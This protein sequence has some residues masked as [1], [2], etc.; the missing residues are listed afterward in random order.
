MVSWAA[1]FNGEAAVIHNC[2]GVTRAIEHVGSTALGI[3]SKDVVDVLVGVSPAAHEAAVADLSRGGFALERTR[4]TAE[5]ERH[6]WLSRLV[7]AQRV[8]VVDL[9]E[10]EGRNG[11][12]GRRSATRC[13]VTRRSERS[14][15]PS[16]VRSPA[17][18][19][20]GASTPPA[21]DH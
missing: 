6:T 10:A 1:R 19:T 12:G 2:V 3:E 21:N 4:I 18:L 15:W 16:S 20:T 5:G 17:S 14:T 8:T 7:D 13:D 11:T 9:V